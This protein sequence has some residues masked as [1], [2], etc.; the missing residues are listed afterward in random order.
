MSERDPLV[1]YRDKRT[2]GATPE[3]GV[4]VPPEDAGSEASGAPTG[5]LFVIHKH[6]ASRLHWDLRLELG[7]AL[8]SWAVPKGPSLD[9]AEKRL[10]VHV[11]DHPLEYVDFED[12]IP[13]GNYGAGPMIVWDRGNWVALEDPEAG[14]LD[15]KLLFE[16]RGHKLRGVWTLVKLKKTENEW[17]L[18]REK[19]TL[20]RAELAAAPDADAAVP[21]ESILSG[22]TVEELGAGVD[23]GDA[24]ARRA[25][26]FGAPRRTV[27]GEG[28]KLMLAHTAK[29]PFSD[30]E[31]LFELKLDGYRMIA[32]R[33]GHVCRLHTRNGNDA[34][35]WFPEIVRALRSLPVDDFVVDG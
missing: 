17:L 19:R 32:A 22:L 10:A 30:P 7:G 23:R 21:Q 1:R 24:L 35:S 29:A 33:D 25:E 8:R 18:I 2:A 6:A 11:E 20:S 34:T 3:P 26:D 15:G 5:G 12:V 31:W 13:P 14:M 28:V 9:P 16:L 27:R 4:A